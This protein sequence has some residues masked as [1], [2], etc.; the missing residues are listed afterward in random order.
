MLAATGTLAATAGLSGTAAA[1]E[2]GVTAACP[3][4]AFCMYT[5]ANQ[6]GTMYA[7]YSNWSGTISGIKSVYNNGNPQPGYDHVNFTWQYNGNTFTKCFHYPFDTPYKTNYVGVTAKK[8]V[9]R[10]EC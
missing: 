3:R 10:G 4:G 2:V 8:V 6:T 5:G 9:W 1:G 7:R